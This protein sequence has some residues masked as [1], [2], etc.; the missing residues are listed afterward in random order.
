MQYLYLC[1]YIYIYAYVLYICICI[2]IYVCVCVG[3]CLLV[4]GTY[5]LNNLESFMH[6]MCSMH[7]GN[8][9]GHILLIA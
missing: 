7:F 3:L 6:V 1:V 2:F 5:M 9:N 4:D 8:N